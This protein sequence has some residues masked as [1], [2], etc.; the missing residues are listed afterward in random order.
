MNFCSRN[1]KEIGLIYRKIKIKKHIMINNK[2]CVILTASIDPAGINFLE[3]TNINERYSDYCKSVKKYLKEL[4]CPIVFC[5]NSNFPI[6]NDSILLSKNKNYE[7]LQYF[8]Q[9][10]P[11]EYGKGYGF[12]ENID[13]AIENSKFSKLGLKY[14][15]ITGRYDVKNIKKI[16]NFYKDKEFDIACDLSENLSFAGAGFFIFSKDFFKNYLLPL[17]P[18]INDKSGFFFEHALALAV[19]KSMEKLKWH[20][21]YYKPNIVGISGT[22]NIK[23]KRR[24]FLSFLGDFRQ[25]MKYFL[26]K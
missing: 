23:I 11:R 21:F 14:I 24:K 6:P 17:K 18:K 4:E 2:F 16:M 8:G 7:F 9:D 1:L 19:H 20:P 13:F 12:M 3:R 25:K 5:E 15:Q 26:L 22:R 10:F